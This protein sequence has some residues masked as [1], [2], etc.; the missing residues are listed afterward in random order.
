MS[1]LI[2]AMLSMRA[3]Y[4]STAADHAFEAK[5]EP[6]Q[7]D[8]S[9]PAQEE[10]NLKDFA[11][12][13]AKPD[14]Q[15]EDS[16]S[17]DLLELEKE[18][19]S[20]YEVVEDVYTHEDEEI[21]TNLVILGKEKEATEALAEYFSRLGSN[22]GGEMV[23]Y[24]VT[25]LV[26]TFV[27]LIANI[28]ITHND[29]KYKFDSMLSLVKLDSVD[30]MKN[31]LTDIT[32]SLCRE[33]KLSRSGKDEFISN[34]VKAYVEE[35]FADRKLDVSTISDFLGLSPSYATKLFKQETG[36]V[37]SYYIN[38]VRVSKARELLILD[39]YRVEQ[40]AHM[41]GYLDSRALSRAF[42]RFYGVTPS[43]YKEISYIETN[44]G[45]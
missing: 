36:E 25:N 11:L 22:P 40:V 27:K 18:M 35:N 37:L 28:K 12:T 21:F 24:L 42:K 41:V 9:A 20:Q 6:S 43:Q 1:A 2:S 38:R 39:M 15:C 45:I 19:L 3:I 29:S 5:S 34:R 26:R 13:E 33:V 4:S 16:V 44:P 23:N 17:L 14:N 30:A 32:V 7:N 10:D 31:E 8:A